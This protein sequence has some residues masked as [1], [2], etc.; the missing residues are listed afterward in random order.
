[1]AKRPSN[2]VTRQQHDRVATGIAP[3]KPAPEVPPELVAYLEAL[4]PVRCYDPT[5]ESLE[6]H[7]MHSGQVY[8][9][10]MMRQWME[11]QKVAGT[12]P[13]EEE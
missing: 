11:D 3:E 10:G 2:H 8:L 12:D 5:E 4:I 6:E 9:V 13:D 7:L 1:M